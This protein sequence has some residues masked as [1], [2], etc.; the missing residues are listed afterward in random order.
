MRGALILVTGWL[1]LTLQTSA[2]WALPGVPSFLV[3]IAIYLG[4]TREA[5]RAALLA[6]ALGYLADLLGGAPRGQHIFLAMVLSLLSSAASTRF[7]LRG[8]VV[9]TVA[10]FVGAL[11]MQVLS[12]AMLSA[13]LR[14][15]TETQLLVGDVLPV[16]IAT[17]VFAA[18]TDWLCTRIDALGRRMQREDRLLR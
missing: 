6:G 9:V 14:G 10:A 11:L 4:Y 8:P 18:P 13:F 7:V 2:L 15:L 17:A 1:L 12:L 3:P 5:L 16:A